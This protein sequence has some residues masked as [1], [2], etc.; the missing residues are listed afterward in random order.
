VLLSRNVVAAVQ[1]QL[2]RHKFVSSTIEARLKYQTEVRVSDYALHGNPSVGIRRSKKSSISHAGP[3]PCAT[4]A[5]MHHAYREA[6]AVI[7][8]RDG[9]IGMGHDDA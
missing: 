5:S 9:P 8:Q 4:G 3:V 2:E 7:E 6:S 1:V